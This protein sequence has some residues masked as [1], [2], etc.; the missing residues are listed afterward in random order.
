MGWE[1]KMF[2][3]DRL[4]PTELRQWESPGLGY[5]FCKQGK[6]FLI[7]LKQHYPMDSLE[8]ILFLRGAHTCGGQRLMSIAFLSL[9]L[10][11]WDRASHCVAWASQIWLQCLAI[12]L[13]E[14]SCLPRVKITNTHH[15]SHLFTQGLG[16]WTQNLVLLWQ[17]LC[18]LSHLSKKLKLHRKTPASRCLF[19]WLSTIFAWSVEN[20][21]S[22]W[23]SRCFS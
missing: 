19:V 12:K 4:R 23:C 8:E 13:L 11:S 2:Q 21:F 5:V 22:D 20:I 18:G 14:P 17:A 6:T 16:T 3:W 15:H 9:H 7:M 10:L 1:I